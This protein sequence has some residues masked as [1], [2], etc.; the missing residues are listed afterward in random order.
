MKWNKP[1]IF[2]ARIKLQLRNEMFIELEIENRNYSQLI[3]VPH[4]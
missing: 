4:M 1:H 2:L 3:I